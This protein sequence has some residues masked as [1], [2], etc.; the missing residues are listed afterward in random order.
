MTARL[1]VAPLLA[2]QLLPMVAAVGK[3]VGHQMEP[4]AIMMG[5][6]MPKPDSCVL[7]TFTGFHDPFGAAPVEGNEEE[8][9]VLSLLRV[10]RFDCVILLSTP[11]TM[12][13]TERTE[14]EIRARHPSIELEVQ[15]LALEDPTDY[16]AIMNALRR[17][18][19]AIAAAHNGAHYF[20]A[21]ASGTPQM[22]ASWVLL[23]ASGEI[24]AR[25]L[26]VRPPRFVSGDR[27]AVTEI[28][29][30]APEFPSI[31]PKVWSELDAVP[32][33]ECDPSEVIRRLG[34]VGNHPSFQS[35]LDTASILARSDLSLLLLGESGTGKEKFARLV[36]ALSNR[37]QGPFIPV[38]CAAVPK[39]LAE[40]FLFGHRKGAF[41]G[42]TTNSIG[43]FE[44]AD[45]GTLFLDEVAEMPLEIQAKFLRAIQEGVIEPLGAPQSKPISVRF[46]A[47]TNQNLQ[48]A[49]AE[50]RFRE[51]LYYR[52]Q[53]AELRI[54]PLRERRS[55]ISKLA[56]SFLDEVN[57]GL[58]PVRRFTPEALAAIHG[59]DWPGNVRQL[60]NCVQR[61]A[62]LSRGV[63]I[64]PEALGLGPT[65]GKAAPSPIPEPQ[66][67]FSVE[68]HLGSVRT[69]LYERAL[70]LAGG[71]QSEAARLLSVSPQAVW[72][73]IKGPL[74]R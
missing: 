20:V 70:D 9:P 3:V 44:A 58:K 49:L 69:A 23:T 51:D 5:C 62:I 72:K 34:I 74:N 15:H 55:D 60:Q 33:G 63:E 66:V 64:R 47:A 24:P 40:S 35:A 4:G 54:P 53:V 71:N 38:N 65:A 52:L 12:V 18:Y 7:L 57:L 19:A 41:T 50:G 31:R 30:S 36:H 56:I 61:A 42:A 25:I 39:E 2:P 73:F 28:D 14:Q 32:E 1:Y 22:H 17:S 6:I 37:S 26:S 8:G 16:G 45:K 10:R 59:Y 13:Q 43:R 11:R 68:E 21:T 27:A 67:G 29:F 46:I 48:T